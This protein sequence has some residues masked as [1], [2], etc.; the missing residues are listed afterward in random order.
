[1]FK[2]FPEK[3][4]DACIDMSA[5]FLSCENIELNEILLE[6]VKRLMKNIIVP[7]GT[8]THYVP[9]FK[10][11]FSDI[12]LKKMFSHIGEILYYNTCSQSNRI[13]VIMKVNNE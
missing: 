5:T 10:S 2:Y 6:S 9:K 11:K 4:Y 12:K 13:V 8:Y 1:M 7:G 3:K